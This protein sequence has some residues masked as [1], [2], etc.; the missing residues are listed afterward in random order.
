M[1]LIEC[2]ECKAEVSDRAIACPKCGAP[3]AIPRPSKTGSSGR[4]WKVLLVLLGLFFAVVLFFSDTPEAASKRMAVDLC[5]D[6]LKAAKT[7]GEQQI[8]SGAC[9]RLERDYRAIRD[10]PTST[11]KPEPAHVM[12]RWELEA[13]EEAQ[14]KAAQEAGAAKST[15]K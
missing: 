1:A 2:S 14:Q 12:G 7:V 11:L 13:L 9:E 4:W 5:R 3:V 6:E 10:S 8:I 15:P